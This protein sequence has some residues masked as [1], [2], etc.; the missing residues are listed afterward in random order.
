L[1]KKPARDCLQVMLKRSL[2]LTLLALLCAAALPVQPVRADAFDDWVAALYRPFQAEQM[3][4]APDGVHLAYTQHANGQLSIVII[5]VDNP[6]ARKIINVEGD[7]SVL[8]A[9]EK[10]DAKL[11]YLHWVSP[12]RL[13]LAPTPDSGGAQTVAEIIAID[14]DGGNAKSLVDMSDFAYDAMPMAVVTA[15]SSPSEGGSPTV[16]KMRNFEIIGRPAGDTENI[17]VEATGQS[18]ERSVAG[19]QNAISGPGD[20]ESTVFTTAG[21][22][23]PRVPFT[24]FK[25]NVHTGKLTQVAEEMD[26]GKYLYDWQGHPRIQRL[27]LQTRAQQSFYYLGPDA[28]KR[29]QLMDGKWSPDVPG[30]FKLSPENYFAERSFPL[31]IDFAGK[32]L[33]YASN[34]GRDTFGVYAL[35]TETRR[36]VDFALEDPHIDL[37]P[38][39]PQFPGASTLV[40]DEQRQTL[41]GVRAMGAMPRTL[42]SDPELADV[43]RE[44]DRKFPHRAAEVLEWDA[45]RTRFLVRVTG[46]TEPGRF[47]IY[48]RPENLVLEFMRRAPWLRAAELNDTRPFEF[49]TPQGVHLTGYLTVPRTPRRDPPPVLVYFAPGNTFPSRAVSEFNREAQVLA[50]MGFVVLRINHRGSAG[51]G[52]RHRDAIQAG[53]DRVVIEDVLA[54]LDWVGTRV[55]IDRKRVATMG[56]GFGGFLALR[57]VEIEPKAFRCAVSI[58]APLDLQMWLRP[59]LE[60]FSSNDTVDFAQEVQRAYFERGQV[61]LAD[62]S[63]LRGADRISRAVFLILNPDSSEEITVETSALRSALKSHGGTVE[64]LEVN[65]DFDRSLPAAR[66]DAFRKI[67]EFFNLNLYNYKAE[68]GET[69][70]LK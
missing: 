55:K 60:E 57:A 3:A 50:G 68:V 27:I 69:Q 31:G 8:F 61:K 17:L 47:F 22:M 29:W 38:L 1:R 52:A 19:A 63:V 45:A 62:L 26:F 44:L 30:G 2:P 24:V 9:K 46:G 5:Q 12:N 67:D 42:W 53:L 34:I 49:D 51:F 21:P 48:Q 70:E 11:R 14:A 33:Y 20:L 59:R 41:V 13:V 36:R 7:R 10:A 66:A 28:R 6:A 65:E 58:N 15:D 56:E 40:F 23:A 32:R 35:D 16:H 64:Y 43:Q 37:V 54:T 18:Q 4:L 39:E 25:V